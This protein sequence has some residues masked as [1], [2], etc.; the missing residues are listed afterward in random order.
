[1]YV[2]TNALPVEVP[3]TEPM[4]E[5]GVEP[6]GLFLPRVKPG[7]RRRRACRRVVRSKDD[8]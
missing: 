7:T 8:G 2:D 5:S 1:M 6:V 4:P 3:E